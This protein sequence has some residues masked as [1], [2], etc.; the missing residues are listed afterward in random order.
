MI[1]SHDIEAFAPKEKTMSTT[2]KLTKAQQSL[3]D[4]VNQKG[5]VRCI[6]SYRPAKRLFELGLVDVRDASFGAIR[7]TKK[8]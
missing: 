2:P 1:S 4:E 7:L 6:D 8:A 5:E 3:L